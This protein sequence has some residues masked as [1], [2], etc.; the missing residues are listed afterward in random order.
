MNIREIAM[1]KP[2]EKEEIT[3]SSYDYDKDYVYP[4]YEDPA[5]GTIT[6]SFSMTKEEIGP[7]GDDES[8]QYDFAKAQVI[9]ETIAK[10]RFNEFIKEDYTSKYKAEFEVS[11]GY[12]D[13]EAAITLTPI[14]K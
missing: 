10:E 8:D 13:F 14:K 2:K 12:V 4:K 7:I 9:A 6:I 11:E 3:Y 1:G 5:A